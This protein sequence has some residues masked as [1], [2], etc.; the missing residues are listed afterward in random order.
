M[1]HFSRVAVRQDTHCIATVSLNTSEK[2]NPVIWS[3][4]GLPFDCHSAVPVM[5][6]LGMF[7]QIHVNC[8]AR[9]KGYLVGEEGDRV[10]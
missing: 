2:V 9:E 4:T 1:L 7:L 3:V 6:P 8:R 10:I 5:K